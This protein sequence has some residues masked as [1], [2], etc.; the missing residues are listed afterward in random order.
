MSYTHLTKEER[1]QIRAMLIAEF[2]LREIA[3]RLGRNVGTISR[4]IRRNRGQRG[5]RPKQAQ[6]LAEQR[7]QACRR[8]YRITYG[9]WR[10]VE[11]LIRRDWSPEQVAARTRLEG[12][13]QISHE[14]IYQFVYADKSLGGDLHAHLRCQKQ[15]R[16]RYGSGQQR[17]GQIVDRIG[18]DQRPSAADDR[19]EI[20]HWEAD[21][22]IGKGRKGACL[23]AVERQS[24]FTRLAKLN[25][26]TAQA[27]AR[28]LRDRLKPLVRAVRTITFDNGKEFANHHWV[29]NDLSCEAY[30][31]DPY[32][33]WQR[34][35]NENTNGLIRQ[36]LP[37]NRDMTTLTGAEIRMIE[38]R[39]NHRPRKCL[40]YLTP[41][42]VL[43]KTQKSLTVAPR[44]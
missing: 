14:W 16:K 34:G 32:A 41:H 28:R 44:S 1:Y 5:Y 25:R 42:E 36:Y 12:T 37:K 8:R 19:S 40:G 39:L 22:I 21:T 33:S 18:I 38:N 11:R 20:G 7:A 24:R 29:S 43:H 26:R 31:A 6:E 10:C 23:T 9:Q 30:F 35:T 13:V 3:Q 15:R 4:E 27:T 2:S 17:R